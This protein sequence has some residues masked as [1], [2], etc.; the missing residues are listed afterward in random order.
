MGKYKREHP[1]DMSKP[2]S[3]KTN[4]PVTVSSSRPEFNE[5]TWGEM[6]KVL[7]TED[8]RR[9]ETLYWEN[10]LRESLFNDEK[11][12]KMDRHGWNDSKFKIY[13]Y[14]TLYSL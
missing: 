12:R 13:N 3:T 6:A 2:I 11:T 5:K 7:F 8:F 4:L 14:V 10:G 9:G 1:V